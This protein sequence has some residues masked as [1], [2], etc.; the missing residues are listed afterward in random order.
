MVA[1]VDGQLVPIPINLDTIN[2][3]TNGRLTSA[4]L[5]D[6]FQALA[7]PVADVRTSEDVIVSKIG[8]DLYEKF[9]RHYT[10]KHSGTICGRRA[11]RR[12]SCA[13]SPRI[14]AGS[15]CWA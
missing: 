12:R 14:A 6:Y 4:E 2:Q 1:A 11:R 13:P 7:E 8:R 10:R 3:L 15:T 9:F 5:A